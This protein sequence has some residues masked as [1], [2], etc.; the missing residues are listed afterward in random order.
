MTATGFPRALPRVL[1]HEGGYVNHASDP[2]GATNKGVT[3]RVYDA[4]R[5]R[6]GLPTRD[7]REITSAEVSEIYKLQYWDAVHG[8]Q[9]PPGI[10]YVLF[11]GAVNSGPSQSIKWLQ[12]ALGNVLVDGQMGQATLQAVAEH[13]RPVQLV[14]AICDR[15]M[16]FLQALRTWGTFGK[17][18]TSRVSGVRRLGKSWAL[19][20]AGTPMDETVKP[21]GKG[22]INDA[23]KPPGKGA[24]DATTGGGIVTGGLGGVLE[25]IRQQLEPFAQAM[26]FIG[27]LVAALIVAGAILTLG[28]MAYRWWAARKARQLADALDLPGV[29][30]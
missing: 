23:K 18:W 30:A 1:Q 25:T 9:L 6:K 20:V 24:A 21:T 27:R 3:F 2:G 28:G 19:G 10:D 15:R 17:G 4:Y 13:P 11:D 29:A 14:D 22:S 8:D 5:T 7:V 12:K 16:A 26:P